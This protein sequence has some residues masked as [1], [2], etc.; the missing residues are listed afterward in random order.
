MSS[1]QIR[2]AT[3]NKLFD[4]YLP[5]FE[6][7]ELRNKKVN[8]LAS[9]E[10]QQDA[11]KKFFEA[12]N[13]DMPDQKVLMKIN[14]FIDPEEN[15]RIVDTYNKNIAAQKRKIAEHNQKIK[16]NQE[17]ALE[18][19]KMKRE[20]YEK[21]VRTGYKRYKGEELAPWYANNAQRWEEESTNYLKDNDVSIE[22][23][24]NYLKENDKEH[25]MYGG[26]EQKWYQ[27]LGDAWSSGASG[28]YRFVQ[29]LGEDTPQQSDNALGRIE[30]ALN[31][32]SKEVE[33]QNQQNQET[34]EYNK[35]DPELYV[36]RSAEIMLEVERLEN[37]LNTT[38]D[39]AAQ[40]EI[41]TKIDTLQN[42]LPPI[43]EVKRQ[44][45]QQDILDL[46]DLYAANNVGQVEVFLVVEKI[47]F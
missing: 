21:R 15:K 12:E 23:M 29:A 22:E 14:Q 7:Q 34:I 11:I 33:L 41:Q 3:Y 4:Q 18:D 26:T 13:I 20:E 8:W 1:I 40:A 28:F 47:H 30:Y 10:N 31:E 42:E 24:E 25:V 45:V 9:Q 6:D 39:A 27:D 36:E 17:A 46:Y 35:Y 32:T 44:D 5:D 19:E 43:L 16:D 2:T 37:E 38:Q